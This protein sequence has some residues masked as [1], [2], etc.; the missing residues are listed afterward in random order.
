MSPRA[1]GGSET[2]SS[3]YGFPHW[4]WGTI[5]AGLGASGAGTKRRRDCPDAPGFG[6]YEATGAKGSRSY[7]LALLLRR[8]GKQGRWRRAG[9]AG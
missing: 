6:D 9:D 2:F 4:L 8:M 3:E 1:G 5:L 7:F